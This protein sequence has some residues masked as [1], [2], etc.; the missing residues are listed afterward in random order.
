[1]TTPLKKRPAL[2]LEERN[3]IEGFFELME[4][5]FASEVW[6]KALYE[7]VYLPHLLGGVV[8]ERELYLVE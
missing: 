2:V 5:H 4:L 3:L 1:M 7:L 6:R 8:C